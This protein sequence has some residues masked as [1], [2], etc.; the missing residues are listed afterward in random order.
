MPGHAFHSWLYNKTRLYN[1]SQLFTTQTPP[2]CSELWEGK[3]G[4]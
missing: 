1:K 3:A 2:L 4:V